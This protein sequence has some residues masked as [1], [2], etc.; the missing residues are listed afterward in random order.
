MHPGSPSDPCGT[1]AAEAKPR[2]VYSILKPHFRVPDAKSD[3]S[4]RGEAE[5]RILNFKTTW[6]EFQRPSQTDPAKDKPRCVHS[7]LKPHFRVSSPPQSR[8]QAVVCVSTP[9]KYSQSGCFLENNKNSPLSWQLYLSKVSNVKMDTYF[10]MKRYMDFHILFIK[11]DLDKPMT[12]SL[13]FRISHKLYCCDHF[14][15]SKGS[16][17]YSMKVSHATNKWL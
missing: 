12:P 5:V 13:R 15:P 9:R 1:A 16:S 6:S 17:F 4:R 8:S 11:Q 10:F 3:C 7:I 14:N 2:Y